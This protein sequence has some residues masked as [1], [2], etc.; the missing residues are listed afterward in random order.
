MRRALRYG[1]HVLSSTG[2]TLNADTRA[3]LLGNPQEGQTYTL[4]RAARRRRSPTDL[5]VHIHRYT[6]SRSCRRVLDGHIGYIQ[7]F[8]FYDSIPQELDKALANL[9]SR[10]GQ[11][12]HR[13]PRQS[14]AASMWIM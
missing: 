7:T 12:D 10:C 6:G 9:H 2:R 1:D 4:D 14:A 3:A 11:P 5:T 13:L 8:E